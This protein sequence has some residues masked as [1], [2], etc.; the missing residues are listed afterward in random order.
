MES[1]AGHTGKAL[2]WTADGQTFTVP[3]GALGGRSTG[4]IALWARSDDAQHGISIAGRASPGSAD[5]PWANVL[6]NGG[7][8]DEVRI[9]DRALGAGEISALAR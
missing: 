7:A 2:A 6:A 5:D 3:A 8:I 9:Y 1:V 4:T